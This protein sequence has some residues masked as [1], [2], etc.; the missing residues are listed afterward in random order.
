MLSIIGPVYTFVMKYCSQCGDVVSHRIPDGD[1]R[2]RFVCESCD[3]IHYQNPKIVTG[4]L[5]FHEKRVLLCKRSIQPRQGFWTLPA[6]FLENGETTEQGALRE[7]QEE[8]NANAEIIELYTLF[9]LPHIS[10]IYLFYR[11]ELTDLDFYPG[12][13][14]LETRLF[15][16]HEIPWDNLAFPVITETLRHFF[17][18]LPAERFPFRSQDIVIDRKRNPL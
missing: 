15:E 17:S 13:E 3:T 1:N 5:P 14:T 4:C 11:A 2:A 8:A 7:T 9:S 18:D 12:A 6:G 16:E 10:Q